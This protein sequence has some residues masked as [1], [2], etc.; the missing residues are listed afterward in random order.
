MLE[1]FQATPWQ[2]TLGERTALEGLLS[3][4][5][6]RLAVEIGTAEGGSLRRLAAHSEEVHSFDLVEPAFDVSEFGHVVLHTGDSHALLPEALAGFA[7]AGRSVDFVLVDGD[8]SADGVERDLLDLLASPAVTSTVIVL[9]DTLNPEV[10]EGLQRVDYGL[11]HKVALVDLDLVPGHLS[12]SGVYRGHLWG[13]LG[14]VV[15]GDADGLPLGP[16]DSLYTPY[17]VFEPVSA[18][19]IRAQ[20]SGTPREPGEITADAAS[21]DLHRAQAALE[22]IQ[23]S[24]SW[25]IT[26]PLRAAKRVVRERR[27]GPRS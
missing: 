3:Q 19:M 6:P 2:M 25:R 21:Q 22:A 12:R 9:H 23:G 10:R 17:D 11:Y 26:A 27:S 24:A 4:V 7:A 13:G 5:K 15:V 18:A 16:N 1:I 8:H 14:V 20:S